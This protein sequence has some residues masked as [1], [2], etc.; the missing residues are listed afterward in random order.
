M[1]RYHWTIMYYSWFY[2]KLWISLYYLYMLRHCINHVYWLYKKQCNIVHSINRMDALNGTFSHWHW[3]C[4]QP[5]FDLLECHN[6]WIVPL[7]TY[8]SLQRFWEGR[9]ISAKIGAYLDRRVTV[10]SLGQ[11]HKVINAE[12]VWKCVSQEKC[13]PYMNNVP[14]IDQKVLARTDGQT[15]G[16]M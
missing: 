7:E 8:T 11:G 6:L 10:G 14:C 16:Q 4:N 9:V 5:V 2:H 15:E 13:I 12:V 1:A 3:T